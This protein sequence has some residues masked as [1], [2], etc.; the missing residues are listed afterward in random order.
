M[1]LLAASRGSVSAAIFRRAGQTVG[2]ARQHGALASA[3]NSRLRETASW[4]SIARIG[5]RMARARATTT[6]MPQRRPSR[7]GRGRRRP[8][9][10]MTTGA[11]S[12][13]QG[14]DAG[15][16]HDQ[17][18]EPDVVVLDVGHLV[19]HHALELRP[20]HLLQQAGGDAM[21]RARG[22]ARWRRRWGRVV[23]DVGPA[24]PAGRPRW[25]GPPHVEEVG[26][27][28]LV[29]GRARLMPRTILSLA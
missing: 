26:E 25:P 27:L 8:P 4:M 5:D 2:E 24:A 1:A 14:H 10:H 18:L 16:D 6:K 15:H 3:R 22:R 11:S 19:G 23:D 29:A 20:V 13:E 7:R 28:V 9:P 21:R 12:H 17:R